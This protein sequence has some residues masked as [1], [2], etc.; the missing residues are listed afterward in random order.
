MNF[1]L[2]SNALLLFFVIF[3]PGIIAG[4]LPLK[5][6]SVSLVFFLSTIQ[7]VLLLV[8][9]YAIGSTFYSRLHD[10]GKL[11]LLFFRINS[12]TPILA[13][14][15]C[16]L[17]PNSL[18]N[19]PSVLIIIILYSLFSILYCINFAAKVVVMFERKQYVGFVDY[20]G[21]F[22]LFWF[23]P[24]GVWFIQPKIHKLLQHKVS[25]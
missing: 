10:N 21:Y 16:G 17:I 7:M 15:V 25:I 12:V 20:A 9:Y 5:D 22:F 3:F 6:M 13:L 1:F 23:F 24:V 18:K 4:M 19:Y 14:L 8:W 2:K 11:N